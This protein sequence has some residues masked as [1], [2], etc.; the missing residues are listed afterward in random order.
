MNET[1]SREVFRNFSS[2]GEGVFYALATLA[3]AIFAYGIFLKLRKYWQGRAAYRFDRLPERFLRAVAA[4]AGN[5]TI[6][7]NDRFAGFVHGAIM[8]GFIALFIGTTIIFIDNE[9][10]HYWM[11]PTV[12]GPMPL[13]TL[14]IRMTDVW[15]KH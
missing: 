15:A 8:W 1:P 10:Q 3:M 13:P 12:S 14:D 4:A 5:T 6:A 9:L 2:L 11:K 7:K